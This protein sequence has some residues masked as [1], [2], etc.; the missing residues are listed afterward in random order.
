MTVQYD[1]GVIQSH[2]EALYAQA[3]RIVL[4]F[5][6][7]GFVV[8]A[9]MGGAAG[10]AASGGGTL[11]LIGGLVGALIGG[12]MG[13]SRAFVLHLQA[14]MALCNVAI[15]ANTRRTADATVSASRPAEVAQ[16]SHAG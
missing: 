10:S 11:A 1:P 5:A 7:F 12:S 8:G 15:E 2:A 13:R 6:F 4:K 16:L 14:Q 3:R 9:I